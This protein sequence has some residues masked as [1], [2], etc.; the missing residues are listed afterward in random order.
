MIQLSYSQEPDGDLGACKPPDDHY[1]SPSARHIRRSPVAKSR[2]CCHRSRALHGT[3]LWPYWWQ[4]SGCCVVSPSPIEDSLLPHFATIGT[5]GRTNGLSHQLAEYFSSNSSLR[6]IIV[7]WEPTRKLGQQRSNDFCHTKFDLSSVQHNISRTQ[8]TSLHIVRGGSNLNR[9]GSTTPYT[10][11]ES[12]SPLQGLL[13][14][15]G[16]VRLGLVPE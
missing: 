9:Y 10:A 6:Q 5:L 3:G 12:G 4:H 15:E 7:P 13:G 1:R 8:D 2:A 11:L 16:H 14:T